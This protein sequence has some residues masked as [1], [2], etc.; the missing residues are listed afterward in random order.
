MLQHTMSG[1]L[2]SNNDD[3]LT[4][5]LDF[6][7][8]LA[9]NN[10]NESLA[11]CASLQRDFLGDLYRT[12]AVNVD[13]TFDPQP[14]KIVRHS[15]IQRLFSIQAALGFNV[16]KRGRTVPSKIAWMLENLRI[17]HLMFAFSFAKRD[18][19]GAESDITKPGSSFPPCAGDS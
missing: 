19:H 10:S 18:T 15:K 16:K 9:L 12:L 1:L 11:N 17:I 13:R 2:N 14:D 8:Q 7:H 5:M 4:A 6:M 3:L